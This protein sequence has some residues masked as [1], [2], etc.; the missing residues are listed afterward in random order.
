MRCRVGKRYQLP[1]G[2]GIYLGYEAFED[3]GYKSILVE[4]SIDAR[5][6]N[7]RVFKLDDGHTWP[8]DGNY[9]AFES[10]VTKVE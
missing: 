8:W 6:S 3:N 5:W 2:T 4:K 9:N 1:H 10:D 7:R